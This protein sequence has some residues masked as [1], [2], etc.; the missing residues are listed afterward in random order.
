[1]KTA[2]LVIAGIIFSCLSFLSGFVAAVMIGFIFQLMNGEIAVIESALT[3]ASYTSVIG[4]IVYIYLVITGK[5]VIEA[6]DEE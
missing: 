6:E 5:L 1:M 4:T 3:F 2:A